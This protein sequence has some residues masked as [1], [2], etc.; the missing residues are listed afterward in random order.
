MSPEWKQ[1]VQ[2]TLAV[3]FVLAAARVGYIFYERSQAKVPAARED[4]TLIHNTLTRDDMVYERPFYGY[5]LSSTRAKLKGATVWVKTGHYY[6]YF[7]YGPGGVERRR[8][9]GVLGPLEVLEI[10]DVVLEPNPRANQV[11]AVFRK[12][13]ESR[14]FAVSIGFERNHQYT[15][16]VADEFYRQDPRELY[17]HWPAEVWE[18]I[19]KHEPRKGMNELQMWLTLGVGSPQGSSPGNRTIEYVNNG[20]PVTV[21]FSEGGAVS[22]T[23]DQ[24]K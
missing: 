2:I 20:K 12:P 3:F 23:G 19:G 24:A 5:D 14:L 6:A 9:A 8:E 4:P 15:I 22:I 16:L 11:M 21:R 7:P 17:K 13:G 10:R 1:R 18:A